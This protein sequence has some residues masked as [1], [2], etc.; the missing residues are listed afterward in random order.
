MKLSIKIITVSYMFILLFVFGACKDE[1]KEVNI[2]DIPH[3][4]NQS[5]VLN[6]IE[7]K[8]GGYGSRVIIS[9]T[10]FGNDVSKI[11]LFFNNKE[12]LVLKV[13]NNA[14]YAMVPKQPGDLSTIKVVFQNDET[15]DSKEAELSDVLFKYNIRATVTTVAGKAGENGMEDGTATEGKFTW[16]VKLDVDSLGENIFVADQGALRHISVKDNR[17][18]T[19]ISGLHS[20]WDCNFN[21]SYSKFYVS[22]YLNN[23]R[24]LLFVE[25]DKKSNWTEPKNYYDRKD[26]NDNYIS[27]KLDYF[28]LT[29]D[30]N[31]IYMLSTNGDRLVR[32]DQLTG[33][34]ELM[35]KDL[36]IG[37][38]ANIVFS[39]K[40]KH[41]YINAETKGRIYK[42]DP[43]KN[44]KGD[45][46]PWIG[47]KDVEHI[48][49]NGQQ[50][51]PIEG[52]GVFAQFGTL[53]GI[54]ADREGN[55]YMPDY[56]NHIIWKMDED[57]NCTIIAGVPG[58]SGY[59]DGKPKE[60]LFA[61]PSGVAVTSEGI[62]YVADTG[63]YVIR[64]IAIQ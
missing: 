56:R 16:P 21:P 17:L 19:S 47:Y 51:T 29:A 33:E 2:Q 12:A 35:G 44:Y 15:S 3:N 40:D 13:Q 1:A 11:K 64:S 22:E 4:P 20:P 57:Y 41:I 61:W 25:L 26:A 23:T 50:S 32:I 42:F 49:G 45:G 30:N 6:N 36:G 63:N 59:K 8:T 58:E 28:G 46:Q 37:T 18:T 53:E 38:W 39:V 27:G 14:I 5:I 9:G 62:V 7:P 10:N 60:A 52:N 43:Y 24:P 48:A 54:A 31:Y 55:F 34:V